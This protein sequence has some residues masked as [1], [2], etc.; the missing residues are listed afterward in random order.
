MAFQGHE[1]HATVHGRVADVF[2]EQIFRNVS[3]R[4]LEAIYTFPLPEGASVR[5][6]SMVVDGKVMKGEVLERKKARRIYRS[7]VSRRKDPAL[8]E[9]IDR[10]TYKARVFPIPPG[11]T[12][13]LRLTYCQLLREDDGVVELRYPL[14][15]NARANEVAIKI[16]IL[17][18]SLIG[19]LTSSSHK[20]AVSSLA[21][22]RGS[23]ATQA[24]VDVARDGQDRDF[25]LQIVPVAEQGR[26]AT[27]PPMF[28]AHR[29]AGAPGTLLAL[30]KTPRVARAERS[31]VGKDVVYVLDTS[32]SM[33]GE[34]LD[35]AVAALAYGIERLGPRDRFGVV[36]FATVAKHF[37]RGLEFATDKTKREAIAWVRGRDA[38]GGTALDDA[39]TEAFALGD[40][41]RL[42]LVVLLTDGLPSVGERDP[43]RL[44]ARAR[45][46]N[47]ADQ[48]LFVFGVGFDQNVDFLDRIAGDSRG[49]REYVT[50]GENL[51][52]VLSRFFRRIDHPVL[53]DLRLEADGLAD[54]YPRRLPDLFSGD[55]LIVFCRYAV[56]GP[57][58]LRLYGKLHGRTVTYEFHT[59]LPR[60][61]NVPALPHLW[62][63]RK[64]DF[65][66]EQ[67]RLY[68]KNKELVDE[69]VT[70]G[71][72]HSIVTPYTAGLVVEDEE[73]DGDLGVAP[74]RGPATSPA[75]GLGGGAGRGGRRNLRA[76]G[77]GRWKEWK[78]F[79]EELNRLP[80]RQQ[81]DGDFGSVGQT[82]LAALAFLAAGYTDR[83]SKSE[84]RHA[85]TVRRALRSLITAQRNDGTWGGNVRENAIASLALA[86]A[87]WM[88]GNPRY[89]KPAQR[90]AVRT[91]AATP[92]TLDDVAWLT[93]LGKTS[94]SAGLEIDPD[95]FAAF[96]DRLV[97]LGQPGHPAALATRMLLGHNSKVNRPM[98]AAL[99]KTSW[100]EPETRLW[101]MLTLGLR[102]GAAR[103]ATAARIRSLKFTAD[104]P[105][106]LIVYASLYW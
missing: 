89:K 57:A 35:Q 31:S 26:Q 11:K 12:V 39:L 24:R 10:R 36:A 92:K 16:D 63:E 85:A 56:S 87:Y 90:G 46:H 32:G 1:V 43:R 23:Q 34:K 45:K 101:A 50:R 86:Y 52:L 88:T 66:L 73:A 27:R 44:I 14:G 94:K 93:W 33:S 103:K 22:P 9:K 68:G 2:V 18:S 62:A 79:E 106:T 48:R 77:G 99:L 42:G 3:R 40:R 78:A 7:I 75:I 70:L 38:A 74:F 82:G 8:L 4:P 104:A 91:M 81:T 21:S 47:V 28:V 61:R 97:M 105:L 54:V 17:G 58:K 19:S 29:Q 69:I 30:F 25:V 20:L 49:G 102:G 60:V 84:N 41:K 51:E 67:T 95:R 98:V 5:A 13:S 64:V 71:T 65:L 59:T 72:K 37:R 96:R 55:E 80:L 83:G 53:T 76:G 100:E 6:F 15:G